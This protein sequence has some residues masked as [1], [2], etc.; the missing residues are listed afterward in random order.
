MFDSPPLTPTT[1]PQ[2][3]RLVFNDEFDGASI[4]WSKWSDSSS[5]ESDGG[6]GNKKN[7]QLEWNQGTNCSVSNGILSLTARPADFTSPS[8]VHYDWSS[9]LLSSWPSFAFQYGF[10]EVR[11]KLPAPPGF[12]PSFWT[13][14]TSQ[15][16]RWTETDVYELHSHNPTQLYLTQHS[17]KGGGCRLA[18]DFYPSAAFHTYAADISPRGTKFYVD[19]VQ[20]CKA[21]GTSTGLTNVMLSN[22]VW[23]V[24]PPAPG[25]SGV[26]EV[27]YVRVWQR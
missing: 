6:H 11:A 5:A 19:N 16:E 27:D 4:D 13:W 18:L 24:V 3:W 20:V 26:H 2:S 17:G 7:N 8:G 21:A 12:W 14:Q 1:V 22:F 15:N 9:C 23:S 10:I 25:S